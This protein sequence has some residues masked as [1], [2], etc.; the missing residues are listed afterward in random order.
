MSRTK[1]DIFATTR[2]RQE[3][4]S[5]EEVQRFLS[6]VAAPP[7]AA[8]IPTL[9]SSVVAEGERAKAAQAKG[10]RYI[11]AG[12]RSIRITVDLAPKLHK[13]LKQRCLDED[14]EVRSLVIEGLAAL[15]IVEP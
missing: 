7:P 9:P 6:P 13:A 14:R 8:I 5:A 10:N 11:F 2:A 12:E 15:G 4:P 3:Q 1:V